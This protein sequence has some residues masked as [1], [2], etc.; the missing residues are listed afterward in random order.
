MCVCVRVCSHKQ[1]AQRTTETPNSINLV[2][3]S[4]CVCVCDCA[5]AVFHTYNAWIWLAYEV[6]HELE[7]IWFF[8]W[9]ELFVREWCYSRVPTQYHTVT[10]IYSV[11]SLRF[12]WTRRTFCLVPILFVGRNDCRCRLKASSIGKERLCAGLFPGHQAKSVS[13]E[14]YR[15]SQ[16]RFRRKGV[17]T[18]LC[19][20]SGMCSIMICFPRC[21]ITIQ[22][23]NKPFDTAV[24]PWLLV[25]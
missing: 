17:P 3:G 19:I 12:I 22:W 18:Y 2:H 4:V 23:H 14:F 13:E 1:T 16:V 15:H 5:C 9:N 7:E 24:F 21:I 25:R 8:H 10:L 11:Y 6:E 20:D